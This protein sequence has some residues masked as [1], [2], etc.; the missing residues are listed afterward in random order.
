MG[1][2]HK[3][4]SALQTRTSGKAALVFALE[5][6]FKLGEAGKEKV[7]SWKGKCTKS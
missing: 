3:E 4:V 2:T 7:C 1:T 5:P 6:G